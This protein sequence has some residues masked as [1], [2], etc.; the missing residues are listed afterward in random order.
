M[1]RPFTWT[2]EKLNALLDEMMKQVEEVDEKDCPKIFYI[3][4]LLRKNKLYPDWWPD[5][6]DQI[7]KSTE[8]YTDGKQLLRKFKTLEQNIESNLVV[9]MLTGK[10]KETSGIFTLKAKHKWKDKHE[11]DHKHT[12]NPIQ[13]TFTTKPNK[14]KKEEE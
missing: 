13:I 3:G 14:P 5:R 4:Q 11:V 12:V 1:G 7:K 10:V 8:Y 9:A 2:S 6:Q